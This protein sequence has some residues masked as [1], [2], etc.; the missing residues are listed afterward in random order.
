MAGK[1]NTEASAMTTSKNHQ[2]ILCS[3]GVMEGK[4]LGEHGDDAGNSF[5]GRNF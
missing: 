5:G 1:Q 4:L 2:K 3:G